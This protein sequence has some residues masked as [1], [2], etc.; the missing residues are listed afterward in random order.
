MG[1]F[2]RIKV[3][4]SLHAFF[5]LH[6]RAASMSLQHC[7]HTNAN[8]VYIYSMRSISTKV[9]INHHSHTTCHA[10]E[11][12]NYDVFISTPIHIY[13]DVRSDDSI[14]SHHHC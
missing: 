14:T 5:M 1:Q 2:I 8:K 13:A 6:H 4:V 10:S 11:L 9:Y 3:T 12:C 7:S